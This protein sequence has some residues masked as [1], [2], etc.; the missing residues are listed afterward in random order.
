MAT[1]SIVCTACGAAV[2]YGRLSCPECGELLASVGAARRH[3]DRARGAKA[4]RVVPDVLMS[5]EPDTTFGSPASAS[6]VNQDDTAHRNGTADVTATSAADGPPSVA[7]L[8]QSFARPPSTA[9][10]PPPEAYPP[11]PGAYVP[12]APPP[13][14]YVASGPAL[15]TAKPAPARAWES[16]DEHGQP[17]KAGDPTLAG[18]AGTSPAPKPAEAGPVNKVEEFTG[19]L[20]VA[21]AALGAVGFIL[22]WSSSVI[23]ATGV[24]YFDRWGLA[25]PGNLVI[26]VALLVVLGLALVTNPI[27]AWIR[28]GIPGV[29]LGALLVGLAWPYML[30]PLG[31]QAGLV[32]VV[33]GASALLV[34]GIL[35]IAE[36]RHGDAIRSV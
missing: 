12:P 21:G 32:A 3:D 2:P 13:V 31:A 17:L 5:V 20:A 35:A 24:G 7:R 4:K 8:T 11:T 23:G 10:A 33:I 25:G 26:V 1:T 34:A 19:W 27:P 22:P 15:S 9:V 36:R 6:T 28:V 29:A 14:P 18:A 16:P 30:G